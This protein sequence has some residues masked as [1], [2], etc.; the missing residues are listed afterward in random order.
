MKTITFILLLSFFPFQ[1]NIT[2]NIGQALK[3][4]SSKELIKYCNSNIEIKI[5]GNGANYSL[6]QAEEVLKSFFLNN[7]PRNFTFIH[8]GQ[9]PEGLKY[10]I[11]SYKMGDGSYRVVMVIKDIK[12]SLKIDTIT[13]SKE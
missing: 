12:G 13:F 7:P 11:G 10:N 8:Q 5:D 2:V 4:G 9:S 1:D 6:N 3:A